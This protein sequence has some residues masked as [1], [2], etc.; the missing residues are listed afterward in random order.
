MIGRS[1]AIFLSPIKVAKERGM[2][3]C[4]TLT[5]KKTFWFSEEGE[6]RDSLESTPDSRLLIHAPRA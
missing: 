5:R 2:K 6:S 1:R 4:L 3:V